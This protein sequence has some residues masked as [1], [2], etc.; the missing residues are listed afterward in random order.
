[1]REP[2]F[3][4]NCAKVELWVDPGGGGGGGGAAPIWKERGCASE[5]LNLTPKRE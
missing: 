3:Q 1:M 2:R 5:I 4:V